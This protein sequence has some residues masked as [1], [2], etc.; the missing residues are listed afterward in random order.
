MTE[1][2]DYSYFPILETERLL[3]RELAAG[4]A[5]AVFRIRGDYEV[6]RYNIGPAY[7]TLQQATELIESIT[8]G[9]RDA[10]D[11]RWGITR[12]S[13]PQMVI[14]MCGY[15]YWSRHDHRASIGY[16]LAR[17]CWGQGIMTE[18]L[19]AV[20]QFGFG[21]MDLN[22][23]EADSDIRNLASH[24]VLG[25]LGFKREGLLREQFYD[26]DGYYDLVLFSLLRREYSG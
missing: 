22:R 14:G 7:Q 5:E 3:L 10:I 25:K 2:F 26:G 17:H 6:T 12:R 11:L 20:I 13:N 19:H 24:R 18:A 15:N 16:D 23:I 9:F 1:L 21:Q 4:D 8:G